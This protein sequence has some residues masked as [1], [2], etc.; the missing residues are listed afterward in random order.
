MSVDPSIFVGRVIRIKESDLSEIW[1]DVSAYQRPGMLAR[2]TS[3]R[4]GD[5]A[6]QLE[7]DYSEFE[8]RNLPLEEALLPDDQGYVTHRAA[9]EYAARS[10]IFFDA[11]GYAEQCEIIEDHAAA[12]PIRLIEA[13][14]AQ[15]QHNSYLAFLEAH[16]ARAIEAGYQMDESRPAPGAS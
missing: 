7:V 14:Q 8:E 1:K 5:D 15:E 12:S 10:M 3:A 6:L 2:V 16:L 4:I 9:G 11:S 13:Y